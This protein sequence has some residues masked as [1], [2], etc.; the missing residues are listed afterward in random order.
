MGQGTHRCK[1]T[2][3]NLKNISLKIQDFKYV[4]CQRN[5]KIQSYFKV[6]WNS[7]SSNCSTFSGILLQTWFI[8]H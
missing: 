8:A 3:S 2:N 4:S 5:F 1:L 7:V 6:K